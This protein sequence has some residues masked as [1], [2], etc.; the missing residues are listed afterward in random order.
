MTALD[1]GHQ[2]LFCTVITLD[3]LKSIHFYQP[4]VSVTK[5]ECAIRLVRSDL[6]TA[7]ALPA[8]ADLE[9]HTIVSVPHLCA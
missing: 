2:L 5:F 9:P 3:H 1:R 6:A 7:S 8:N 4:T